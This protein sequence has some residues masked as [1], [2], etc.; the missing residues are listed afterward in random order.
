MSEYQNWF[1]LV[2]VEGATL[3][4]PGIYEWQIEGAGSYVGKFKHGSRPLGDY[5]RNLRNQLA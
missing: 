5:S 2:L 1:T 3:D 4:L